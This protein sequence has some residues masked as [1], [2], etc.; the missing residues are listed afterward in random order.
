[1]SQEWVFA[2]VPYLNAAPLARCLPEIEGVRVVYGKPSTLAEQ[3]RDGRADAAL[4]PVVDYLTAPGF[5]VIEGLG[6]CADGAVESVL[7]KCNR[8]IQRIRTVA[9]DPASRTSNALA[10]ILLEEHLGLAVEMVDGSEGADA[11]VLIGDEALVAPPAPHGDLDLATLWQ[12]MT[13]LPFVF[14]VWVHRADHPERERLASIAHEARRLGEGRTDEL[15]ERYAGML[16]LPADRCRDYLANAIHY[17][18][19]PREREAMD[20]FK[21]FLVA[22]EGT[23]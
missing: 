18:V 16:G 20:R 19:G 2:S 21:Q 10:C 8:P 7:L 9:R 3:V 14:A 5:G 15:A 1:M 11:A 4:L 12:E 6:I 13:G 22:G 23:R 17:D